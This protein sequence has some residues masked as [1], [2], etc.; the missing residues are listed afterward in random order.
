MKAAFEASGDDTASS[1][2]HGCIDSSRLE[3]LGAPMLA[4]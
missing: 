2:S 3:G 1:K 4:A